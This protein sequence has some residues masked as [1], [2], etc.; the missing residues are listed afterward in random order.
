MIDELIKSF[1]HPELKSKTFRRK[2]YTWNRSKGESIQVFNLQR[3][4]YNIEGSE[5]FTFNLGVF[6]PDI[7]HICW[8]KKVPIFI[9]ETD[10]IIRTRIGPVIENNFTGNA[11]DIWWELKAKTDLD[12]LFRGLGTILTDNVLPFLDKCSS[13]QAVHDFLASLG[14]WQNEQP[15]N[16]IYLSILKTKLGDENGAETVLKEIDVKKYKAWLPRI[17]NVAKRISVDL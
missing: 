4:Q 5:S 2:G 1:L 14:G 16:R 17:K 12:I 8:H 10:C 7:H 6:L 15:L 9:K 3:S 11:K 13:N